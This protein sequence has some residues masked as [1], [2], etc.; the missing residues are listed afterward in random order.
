MRN[1]G[2]LLRLFR[3]TRWKGKLKRLAPGRHLLAEDFLFFI[4]LSK[5]IGEDP[6]AFGDA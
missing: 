3:R 1:E 4:D 2:S 6:N 5:E